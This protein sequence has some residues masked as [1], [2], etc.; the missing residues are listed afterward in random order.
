[1]NLQNAGLLLLVIGGFSM[2]FIGLYALNELQDLKKEC[3]DYWV[4][5]IQEICPAY[6]FNESINLPRLDPSY[7]DDLSVSP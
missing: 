7:A 1:M 4:E 3:N 6:N 5:Q 2:G